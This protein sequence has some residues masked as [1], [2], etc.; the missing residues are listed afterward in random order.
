MAVDVPKFT[1]TLE[2]VRSL[3]YGALVKL[4]VAASTC[5]ATAADDSTPRPPV[6]TAT[7]HRHAVEYFMSHPPR[8]KLDCR[9]GARQA[10]L[11]RP[12]PWAR[13]ARRSGRGRSTLA[14]GRYPHGEAPGEHPGAVIARR[15]AR[16]ATLA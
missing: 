1:L 2:L 4:P 15:D 10:A 16:P 13:N 14:L 3:R 5:G 8:M 6:P 9:T 7:N 12:S 11:F